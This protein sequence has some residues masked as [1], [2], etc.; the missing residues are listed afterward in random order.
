MY[1]RKTKSDLTVKKLNI[2]FIP[3]LLI[4]IGL[5]IGYTFLHW[6]LIIRLEL[7]S[8][9]DGIIEFLGPLCLALLV[10]LLFFMRRIKV[11]NLK[12]ENVKLPGLYW[13]VVWFSLSIPNIIAQ[14]YLPK[15]VGKLTRLHNIS[16]IDKHIP[17]KYYSLDKFGI[18]KNNVGINHFY[19]IGG[20]NS[21]DYNI[22]I[23]VV[24][25][26][27]RNQKDDTKCKAFLGIKYFKSIPNRLSA[28]E[29]E[30]NYNSLL[31][32][33]QYEIAH[34]SF[35]DFTYLEKTHN[36]YD[37]DRFKDVILFSRKYS[38]SHAPVLIPQ[39]GAFEDRLGNQLAW[40]FISFA[41]GSVVWLLMVLAPKVHHTELKRFESRSNNL[42]KWNWFSF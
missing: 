26:L 8:V 3:Y 6:L 38:S 24:F 30:E 41:I 14:S 5:C 17:S 27:T 31:A 15:A 32:V 10:S 35:D 9:K 4:S 42:Q 34:N 33:C 25:P 40:I 28:R 18:D 39:K 1:A 12:R 37:G 2:L 16:D 7:F 13:I 22:Y 21:S 19:Q 29:K 20:K 36:N 23:Y 11:L